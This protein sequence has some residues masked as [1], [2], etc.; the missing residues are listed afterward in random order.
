MPR[1]AYSLAGVIRA[2][3]MSSSA[4]TAFVEGYLDRVFYGELLAANGTAS[5]KTVTIRLAQEFHS[6][7]AEGK[8]ALLD[9]HSTLQT[10]NLL[11]FGTGSNRKLILFFLDKDVDDLKRALRD[12]PHIIY[13]EH[14]C[15]ENYLYTHGNLRKALAA[16]ANLDPQSLCGFP[17]N[18]V[19]TKNAAASWAD[20]IAFCLL[21]IKTQP[22][23]IPN[24]G[25]V[26]Q[27][28]SRPYDPTN[29]TSLSTLL[30]AVTSRIGI[31]AAAAGSIFTKEQRRTHRFLARNWFNRIFNGKWY[32]LFLSADAR[33]IASGRQLPPKCEERLEAALL[34]TLDFSAPW[35][36]GLQL[37]IS[38][39]V[40]LF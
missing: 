18:E 2:A 33:T 11:L 21:V 19:W 36:Q 28:N 4:I 8:K 15:T 10:N 17:S 5:G 22:P 7:L 25:T 37:E 12:C 34:A 40:Q 20:W 23:G 13:T 35:A 24:F 6:G 26:S 1:L 16:G 27:F 9:L 29:A 14:Y 31:T 3:Q 38:R 30:T 32:A 39:T